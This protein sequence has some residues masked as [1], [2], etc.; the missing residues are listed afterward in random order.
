ML[1]N[2]HAGIARKTGTRFFLFCVFLITLLSFTGCKRTTP[3]AQPSRAESVLGTI[4]A[5]TL[6]EQATPKLYQ[7][8][9]GRLREIENLMSVNLPDTDV[10][11]INAAAG[12][13]P[14]QVNDEVFT[15]IER[16]LY[17]A[18]IS[19]GAFDPTVGPL[20]SLWG[21][22]TDHPR[23]PSQEEIDAVLPMINWRDV[24]LDRERRTVFLRRPGMALDLG[25]IAKG[26]A[27]DEAEAI[28]RGAKLRR[29]IVDLGGNVFVYGDKPDR[30]P[31][32]V[33]VQDPLAN[34]RGASIGLVEGKNI[35]VVTTGIYE[36]NFEKDGTLYHHVF[37]PWDGYPVNNGLMSV[38]IITNISMNADALSTAVFVLGYGRGSA[39]LESLDGV[40]GIFVFEDMSVR[41]TSGANFSITDQNYRL[42]P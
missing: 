7:D 30:T 13:E 32:R 42:L 34:R 16:A 2:E 35:T 29:A 24:E 11:R 9:F 5:I 40:E 15:V 12:I 41:T 26:F 39:L 25:G 23:V 33:G 31:W 27:A 22:A 37:S 1:L 38:S 8:I 3:R 4:C 19:G 21:I 17:Y 36:R 20:V 28:I 10:A 18:G 14:V 6:Y